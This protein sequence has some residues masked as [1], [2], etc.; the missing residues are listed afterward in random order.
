MRPMLG[1]VAWGVAFRAAG[2]LR[3]KAEL[4]EHNRMLLGPNLLG[5]CSTR[6]LP[7]QSSE[8][9]AA[10][11]VTLVEPDECTVPFRHC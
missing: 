5:R 11:D 10:P 9:P 7:T 8:H 2:T 6:S 3:G 1:S 4:A